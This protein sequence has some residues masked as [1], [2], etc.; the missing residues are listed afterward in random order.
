M[1]VYCGI[2]AGWAFTTWIWISVLLSYNN[3]PGSSV[4]A[5]RSKTHWRSLAVLSVGW[6]ALFVV[7]PKA[8]TF[9]C[10]SQ[11][12]GDY[13]NGVTCGVGAGTYGG[14]FILL[15]LCI[16]AGVVVYRSYRRAVRSRLGRNVNVAHEDHAMKDATALQTIAQAP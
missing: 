16:S 11:E 14:S 8:I 10:S 6:L 2:T 5:T 1:A 4:F 12:S 7:L 13:T 3:R 9:G 15:V